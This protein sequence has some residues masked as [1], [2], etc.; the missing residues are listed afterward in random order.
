VDNI[1]IGLASV[2]EIVVCFITKILCPLD[3]TSTYVWNKESGT[4]N[5]SDCLLAFLLQKQGLWFSV[6]HYHRWRKLGARVTGNLKNQSP[7]YHHPTSS[8]KKKIHDSNFCWKMRVRF[9]LGYR[10]IFTRTTWSRYESRKGLKHSIIC[11]C[12]GRKNNA[13]ST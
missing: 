11:V 9:F 3:A 7:E 2:I 4:G 13:A 8:R 5:I 12:E 1:N 10:G 6:Q